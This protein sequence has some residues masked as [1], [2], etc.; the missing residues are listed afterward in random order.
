MYVI[1]VYDVEARRTAKMLKLCRQYLH[2]VQNSVFE[3]EITEV[4]LKELVGKAREIMD[5]S[6]DSF[7]IFRNRNAKWLDKQIVGKERSG[8]DQFL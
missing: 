5:E 7:I 4:R 6:T 3:G 1:A 8:V 2:W